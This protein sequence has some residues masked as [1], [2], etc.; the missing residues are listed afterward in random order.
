MNNIYTKLFD[1][2]INTYINELHL[3]SKLSTKNREIMLDWIKN[4]MVDNNYD[5]TIYEYVNDSI[6]KINLHIHLKK[7]FNILET[8]IFLAEYNKI[9]FR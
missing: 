1:E 5:N 7:N 6:I 4:N 9:N 8:A 2:Y 3:I